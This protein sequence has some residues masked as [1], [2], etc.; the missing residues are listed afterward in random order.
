MTASRE[1]T[2]RANA[3]VVGRPCERTL[4]FARAAS[5]AVFLTA[6]LACG[7]A[8]PQNAPTAGDAPSPALRQGTIHEEDLSGTVS[9]PAPAVRDPLPGAGTTLAVPE[10][11]VDIEPRRDPIDAPV[12]DGSYELP[13]L[14][15][16]DDSTMPRRRASVKLVQ[17][18]QDLLRTGDYSA[19]LARFERAIDVDSTNPYSLYFV[20]RAHYFLTHYR[21]S[22]NFLDVAES[23]LAGDDRW[24]AEIHVLRARNATAL[25]FHGRADVN[26]IRALALHPR[27]GFA[28]AQLTTLGTPARTGR[29]R[30]AD[31]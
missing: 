22:L 9:A 19:A 1:T 28:L 4:P 18:G 31:R 5:G 13:S 20:A 27:H 17:Q 14:A 3:H 26:Y 2:V 15:A 7:T 24:L 10:T 6:I 21:E 11:A 23:R 29:D 12:P 8:F 30:G 16:F 25:G